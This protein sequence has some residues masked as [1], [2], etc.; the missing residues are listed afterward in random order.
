MFRIFIGYDPR[1]PIALQVLMHSI[2]ARASR[3]VS[4]TP[5][6]LDTLPITR[7]GL[8]DFTYSRYLPPFLCNFQGIAL[9]LDADMLCLGDISELEGYAYQAAVSVVKNPQR[10]EWPSLMVFNCAHPD[11]QLLTP[12]YINSPDS[13]PNKL[14][15]TP[16][17]ELPAEWNHCVGYD[18]PN[19]KAKLAHFTCGIPCF[20]ETKD[21]EFSKEWN[22]EA[23]RSVSSVSWNELMGNSVHAPRVKRGFLNDDATRVNRAN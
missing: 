9:F 7:R 13:K 11:N 20:N 14:D 15:W 17:G 18:A 1:Q 6:V 10:F 21:C 12:E 22:D 5:L 16:I 23:Y 4:I 19:P 2:Y 3:P 8:T